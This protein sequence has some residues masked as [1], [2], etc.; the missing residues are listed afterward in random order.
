MKIIDRYITV[1]LLQTT[2]IALIVLLVLFT[3]LSLIDQLE[4]TGRG[5]Y[6][7]ITAINYVLLTLPRITYEL[8]PIAAVMGSMT[9]LGILA[10]NSELVII[11]V[12]G[13]SLF[14]LGYAIAKGG[15][16]IVVFAI[17]LGEFIAP[18]CEHTAQNMRSVALTEQIALKTKNGFWSRDGSSFI[19]IR[20]ILP[21]DQVEDIYIY[22]FDTED[23]LRT[24][25]YAKR[26]KYLNDQWL[27]EDIE[28]SILEKGMI[29]KKYLKLAAWESLL[30]P[31]VLNLITMQPQYLTLPELY[32][33]IH[34]LHQNGQNSKL[35]EQA[36]WSKIINPFTIIA[37]IVLAVPLVNAHARMV[38]VSQRIFVGCF[39]GIT[40]HILNQVSGQMGV[41]YSI[42]SAA[43]AII[44]T[45]LIF[46]V[47]LWMMRKNTR[48]A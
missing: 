23:R 25:T 29:T 21:G 17:V 1:T 37:M 46:T 7:V 9:T 4:Q 11:R 5:N 26:A 38:S 28:Q 8:I 22:E 41:V 32:N 19:N 3:F 14:R 39:I 6:D 10:H 47:T 35:Y 36:L 15:M 34:Y 45:L 13:M 24:S 40:F 2:A 27:L 48:L 31:D 43:S 44:P 18:Y 16:A 20:K 33:Y 42:N 30:N 12:S